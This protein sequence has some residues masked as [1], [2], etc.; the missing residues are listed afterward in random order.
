MS[1]KQ[2]TQTKLGKGFYK[3]MGKMFSTQAQAI[4]ECTEAYVVSTYDL[5]FVAVM[6]LC[7]VLEKMG[8]NPLKECQPLLAYC[9][10]HH[11]TQVPK[12]GGLK[13]EKGK[14][15]N[16][17]GKEVKNYERIYEAAEQG[18]SFLQSVQAQQIHQR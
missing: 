11:V 17:T 4:N 3:L 9:I 1:K 16:E 15:F 13:V 5:T 18:L 14:V 8:Y 2:E 10:Y 7:T 12:M 6:L